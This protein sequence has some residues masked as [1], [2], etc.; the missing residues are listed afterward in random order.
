VPDDRVG[1]FLPV[2][3]RAAEDRLHARDQLARVERLR[4]VVV[5][6][7]LEA[8]DPVVNRVTRG[9]HQDWRG[10]FARPQLA[11]EIETIS[12]GEHDVENDDIE[13]SKHGLH[14]AVGVG[15]NGRYLNPLFCKAGPDD[16]RE[17]GVVF[18]K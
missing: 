8:G 18:N 13:A 10:D 5:G 11:T 12:A 14:Q 6:A 15:R 3:G 17:A 2:G 1:D 7:D 9:E 4:Q 16:R